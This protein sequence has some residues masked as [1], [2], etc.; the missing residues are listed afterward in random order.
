MVQTIAE[1]QEEKLMRPIL[2]TSKYLY[3]IVPALF[4]LI[5]WTLF[6]WF[7]QL[8]YGLSVTGLRTPVGAI[9]GLYITNFVFFVAI[10][11]A[12]IAIASG[13]RLFKLKD[14]VALA[15][16]AE[17]ATIFSLMMAGISIVMSLGRPDR[18]WNLIVNFP[19]RVPSSPLTWDVMAVFVYMIFAITYLYVEM[20]EDLARLAGKV[21]W[22]WLYRLLLPGYRPGERHRIERIVFWASIFNFPIMFMMHTTVGW[23]FGLQ[24]G[25]PGWY[26][27]I[28]GPY[29]VLGAVLTGS[30][31][32]I[33]LAAIY[34]R[35]YHWEEFIKPLVFR[36]LGKFLCWFTVLYLYFLMAEYMTVNYAGPAGEQNVWN[37]MTKG[38]YSLF[39]WGQVI[40]L[41]IA[42]HILFFTT[43]FPKIYRIWTTVLASVLIII[44]LWVV[45]FLIV[46]PSLL[47][48]LLPFPTGVYHPSWVEYSMAGGVFAIEILLFILFTRFLPIMPFTDIL[49]EEE[50]GSH[51]A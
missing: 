15:R 42:F 39:F 48:P 7:T 37:S 24:I 44:A 25:R 27:T 8:R 18:L 31:V 32:V 11:A 20:R 40:L 2:R 45:R 35:A 6:A 10:S 22:G 21:K 19:S 3:V 26:S 4:V 23:I 41:V 5:C 13:I 51:H 47:R 50:E 38:D 34:R 1:T 16:M 33:L 46:V 12:G 30:S 43:V 28:F 29:F 49:S 36:G 17:L 9:W 14:Y